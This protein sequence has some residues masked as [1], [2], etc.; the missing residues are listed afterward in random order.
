MADIYEA[1]KVLVNQVLSSTE[2]A[3]IELGEIISTQP[4]KIKLSDRLIL[5][6]SQV[7]LTDA[8]ML[9]TVNLTHKHEDGEDTALTS[10]IIVRDGLKKGDKVLLLKA[11]QGQTYVIISRVVKL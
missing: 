8:V 1:I 2:F 9:K 6:Q 3:D 4:L 7:M 5:N 10:P 11:K